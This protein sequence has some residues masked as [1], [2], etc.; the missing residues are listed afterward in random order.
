MPPTALTLRRTKLEKATSQE[1]INKLQAE[2][3]EESKQALADVLGKFEI[4]LKK[5][6]NWNNRIVEKFSRVPEHIN[7]SPGPR[8]NAQL[9]VYTEGQKPGSL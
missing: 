3:I 1:E 4:V 7:S 5:Y 6:Y 2:F 8:E 9:V